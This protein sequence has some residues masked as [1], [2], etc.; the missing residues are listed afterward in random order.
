MEHFWIC[1]ISVEQISRAASI[2]A[3]IVHS[4]YLIAGT[5]RLL[6]PAPPSYLAVISRIAALYVELAVLMVISSPVQI[7]LHTAIVA[8]G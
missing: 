5:L 3:I 2:S 8:Q 1:A 7:V 4:Q 6:A